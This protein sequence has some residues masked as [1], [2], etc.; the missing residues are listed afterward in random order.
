MVTLSL[1]AVLLDVTG[2][3]D[4]TRDADDAWPFRMAVWHARGLHDKWA[5]GGAVV[6]V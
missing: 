4:A 5:G 6:I 1:I 3:R 2:I